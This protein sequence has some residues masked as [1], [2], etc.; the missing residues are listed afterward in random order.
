MPS[1]T[2]VAFLS[3]CGWFKKSGNDSKTVKIKNRLMI[4]PRQENSSEPLQN[5]LANSSSPLFKRR[6]N[7][8]T[9]DNDPS[10]VTYDNQYQVTYE[11]D[12]NNS[13]GNGGMRCLEVPREV[14]EINNQTIQALQTSIKN[15]ELKIDAFAS[16]QTAIQKLSWEMKFV[17]SELNKK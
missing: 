7:D 14:N 13:K 12:I 8:F 3:L 6:Q 17:K 4:T 2:S 16:M 11:L 15:I 10:V 9:M 1:I 5:N